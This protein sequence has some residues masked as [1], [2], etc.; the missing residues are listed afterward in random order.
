MQVWDI[1][2]QRYRE[3]RDLFRLGVPAL[4]AQRMS[5]QAQMIDAAGVRLQVIPT[6]LLGPC[7]IVPP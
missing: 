7:G 3:T 4:L 1:G 5:E 6:Q 2:A